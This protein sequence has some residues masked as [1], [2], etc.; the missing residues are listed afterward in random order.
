MKGLPPIL[1]LVLIAIA[2]VAAVG[3]ANPARDAILAAFAAAAKQADPAFTGFSAERGHAFWTAAHTGGKPDTPSCTSCHTVDPTAAGQTRAG[4]QIA[5]MAV[6][7]T[8]DRFTDSAKVEKWFGRN[9]S[10][11]LGRDC[12]A[13]EK[14]DVITYLAGK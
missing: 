2:G 5:P 1:S 12:T 4:K 14:G 8:P 13:A 10:T 3:V 7:K 11:V 6:S 9:C